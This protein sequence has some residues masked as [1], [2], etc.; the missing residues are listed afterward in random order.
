MIILLGFPKSGT[1]SFNALFE[2]LKFK[3]YH[4]KFKDE[5]IGNI[6]LK[7]K[8]NNKKLLN[9]LENCDCLTQLDVCVDKNNNYWPQLF[10]YKQLYNENP[11]SIFIL[12]KRNPNDVLNSFKKWHNLLERFYKYNPEIIKNKTDENF[13]NFIN[14]HYR[15]V[16]EFFK[17]EPNSKFIIF[18]INKDNIT[19]LN[20]Y[21]DTKN[22]VFPHENKLNNQNKS[23]KKIVHTNSKNLIICFGGMALKMGGILPFEFLNYLSSTYKKN[24]DLYFFIDKNQCWYHKGIDGI[25]ENIDKTV[26]YLNNIIKKSNYKKILFMG[27][28]AGGYASILFGSLCNVTNV[29]AFIPRTIINNAI[30]KK[31]ADLKTIINNKT[32]YIIHGDISIK[33]EKDTH[34]ISQCN[35]LKNFKKC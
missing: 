22:E 4:W 26:L 30:D 33:N 2:K 27:V 9:S 24:T 15:N 29:I 19:K 3:S 16:E 7:N 1:T 21:I 8:N 18:D 34:H 35:N 28:S 12:N 25:T 5:Y 17:N 23:C 14:Q 13:I 32:E 20:T 11:D 6:I 10:D 31:Y